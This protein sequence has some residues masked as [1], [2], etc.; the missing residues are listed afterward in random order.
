MDNCKKLKQNI[1]YY[2]F[3]DLKNKINQFYYKSK[4][5][6]RNVRGENE[7]TRFHDVLISVVHVYLCKPAGY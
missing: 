6:I 7:R 4:R 5:T 3:K 1:E 2:V